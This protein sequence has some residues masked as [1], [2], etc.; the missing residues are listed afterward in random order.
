ME[1]NILFQYFNRMQPVSVPSCSS[2]GGPLMQWCHLSAK[3]GQ[4]A[5][6]GSE[7]MQVQRGQYAGL[8]HS[9]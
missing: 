4:K 7:I 8:V 3:N 6:K 9:E 2:R 5:M 1:T